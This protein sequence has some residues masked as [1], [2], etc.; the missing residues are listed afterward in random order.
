LAVL[1]R[2]VGGC[3][4]IGIGL[5]LGLALLRGVGERLR[6]GGNVLLDLRGDALAVRVLAVLAGPV[7]RGE[8]I[9]IGGLLGVALLGRV[10][11]R[12]RGVLLL[13]LDAGAHRTLAVG[14]LEGSLVGL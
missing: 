6:V 14:R 11:D 12:L 10:V 9:R 4:R 1:V 5:L 13:A 8:G 2:A 7:R 3:E